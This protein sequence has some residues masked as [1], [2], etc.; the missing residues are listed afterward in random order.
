MQQLLSI[1]YHPRSTEIVLP[2][3]HWQAAG[4]LRFVFR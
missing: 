4:L 3:F 1:K 2:F